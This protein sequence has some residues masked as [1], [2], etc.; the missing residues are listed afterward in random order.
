MPHT[1]RSIQRNRLILLFMLLGLLLLPTHPSSAAPSAQAGTANWYSLDYVPSALRGA[2][3][4]PTAISLDVSGNGW[5]AAQVNSEA[6]MMLQLEE[7]RVTP[8]EFRLANL[9]VSAMR[10]S[11]DGSEG[12]AIGSSTLDTPGQAATFLHF[13]NARWS[14]AEGLAR[15]GL[16]QPPTVLHQYYEMVADSSAHNGWAVGV[17]SSHL[18][19]PTLLQLANGKWQDMT[20]LLPAGV[21]FTYIAASP[22]LRYVWAAGYDQNHNGDAALYYL[23]DGKWMS[24]SQPVGHYRIDG[25]AVDG[26]GNG[27]IALGQLDEPVNSPVPSGLLRFHAD[28]SWVIV[29]N[30]LVATQGVFFSAIALD[31]NGNGWAMGHIGPVGNF[32]P[33]TA[34]VRLEGEKLSDWQSIG[35]KGNLLGQQR[36][37]VSG[38]PTSIAISANGDTWAI[39]QEGYLLR[40]GNLNFSLPALG[41]NDTFPFDAPRQDFATGYTLRGPFLDFWNKHGG[42]RQFGLP[43]TRELI[44]KLD[45][46]KEYVIQYTERA[47]FEYH[48]ENDAANQVQLGLLGDK[49]AEGRQNERPFQRALATDN[50]LATYFPLTGHNMAGSIGDYWKHYGGLPVFGY[51]ISEQFAEQSP[52]DGKTYMV[53]YFERNRLEYHP[54]NADPQ[55]K[56]LLGLLGTQQYQR[57]YGTSPPFIPNPPPLPPSRP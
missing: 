45:D 24:V 8:G 17:D 28:G 13:T 56:V 12:W 30:D 55:Y 29:A 36:Y 39:T 26:S 48:P 19:Q 1:H 37:P 52:T 25:L 38:Q 18:D 42:L 15:Q 27:W 3:L 34:I 47:R 35:S 21:G 2:N 14:V 49:L 53:Q 7:N 9:N 46:G 31:V 32:A 5:I 40:Y 51:P 11:N 10:L 54:E 23:K 4:T 41:P 20:S 57:V 16:G 22:D 33:L 50:P 6:T 44:E 43:I